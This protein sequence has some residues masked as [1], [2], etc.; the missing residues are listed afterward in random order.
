MIWVLR[1]VEVLVRFAVLMNGV[2]G[3]LVVLLPGVLLPLELEVTGPFADVLVWDCWG[4]D[5]PFEVV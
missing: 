2:V 5:V 1:G 3:V 4:F